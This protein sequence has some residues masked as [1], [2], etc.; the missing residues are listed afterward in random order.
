MLKQSHGVYTK[1]QSKIVFFHGDWSKAK[2]AI[3][4]TPNYYNGMQ[5]SMTNNSLMD[6]L[7]K[8]QNNIHN[9]FNLEGTFL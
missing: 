5:L 1:L 4:P 6:N 3:S 2:E 7:N 8:Y 9:P